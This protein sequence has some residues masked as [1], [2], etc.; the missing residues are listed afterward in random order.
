MQFPRTRRVERVHVAQPV[1]ARLGATEVV[2]VDLSVLGARVEHHTP[3]PGGNRARLT[4]ELEGERIVAECR[5]V[6]SRLERFSVGSDGLTIYH[7]GLEF[8]DLP[9]AS[10]EALK[11][12]IGRFLSRALEEQKLNARGVMPQHDVGKMPIFRRGGQ[13]TANSKD[14]KESVGGSILPM[15]RM[16]RE[17]GY[18][19]YQLDHSTWRKK[20]T[21]DPGQPLEGFTISALEDTDQAELLCDAY[22][23]SDRE[24]RRMIQL[25]AQLSIMDGEGTPST[26]LEA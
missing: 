15:S 22:A 24:G 16:S 6:R 13:L 21:H 10:R 3:L 11:G 20:R 9:D 23:R 26:R 18:V 14:V 5:I 8:E 12:I 7:S 19:C 2:L 1:V 17:S 25:F 4:F